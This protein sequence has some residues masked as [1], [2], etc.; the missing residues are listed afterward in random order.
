MSW[1]KVDDQLWG[2]P[3]AAEAGFEALGLWCMAGSW[4]SAYKTGGL[5]T[6][7]A[8]ARLVKSPPRRAKLARILVD[9]GLWEVVDEGW[10]FHD[11]DH[12]QPSPDEIETRRAAARTRKRRQREREQLPLLEE[13][14]TQA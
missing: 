9:V 12:F 7:D 8:L 6:R 3:K 11:W 4:S 14:E 1:F 5:I 10:R 2:H 13:D